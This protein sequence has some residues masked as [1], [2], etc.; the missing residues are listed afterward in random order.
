MNGHIINCDEN[1]FLT[2]F[3]PGGHLGVGIVI[4]DINP[5][6]LSKTCR[7]S[8]SM[9]ADMKTVRVGDILFVHAGKRIYGA[10][11]A[12]T[13]FCEDSTISQV[14]LSRNI[15]YYP[16]PDDPTS[17][18]R[19]NIT[20]IPNIG[21]YRRMAITHFIDTEGRNICFGDGLDSNEVFELKLKRKIWSTEVVWC[22]VYTIHSTLP[23]NFFWNPFLKPKF[24]D[25]FPSDA[26]PSFKNRFLHSVNIKS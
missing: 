16:N 8:Y 5:Q 4:R 6:Q 10:F 19:G 2:S 26:A 23:F 22:R 13:E 15:H 21:Y 1:G 7:T 12:V 17:G 25:V 20:S 9:Y 14:F 11:R 18:W 24:A 3:L